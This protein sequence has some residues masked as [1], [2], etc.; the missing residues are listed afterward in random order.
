MLS[1]NVYGTFPFNDAQLLIR[2]TLSILYLAMT[3]AAHAAN[4]FEM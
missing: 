3:A 2:R 1:A 4:H